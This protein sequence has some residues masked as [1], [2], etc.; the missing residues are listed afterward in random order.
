[1][2]DELSIKISA[3]TQEVKAAENELVIMQKTVGRLN[4]ELQKNKSSWGGVTSAVTAASTAFMAINTAAHQ[5]VIAPLKQAMTTFMEFGD[6]LAKTSQ[7]VGIGVESLGALKFAAEQCG[8]NFDILTDG[9]KKFQ[10]Q[11]GAASMGDTSAIEKLGK[12]GI[13]AGS[14]AGLS[15]EDQLMKLADHIAAIGDKATQTRV[16]MELFGKSGFKLLPFFQEGAAGIKKLMAEGKDIG[17]VLGEEGV[18]SAVEMTDAMNRLKTSASAISNVFIANLAPSISSVLDYLTQGAKIATKFVKDYSGLVTS[19][20]ASVAA[21]ATVKVGIVAVTTAL[22]AL[23][24]GFNALKVAMLSN[25][26]LLGGAVLIGAITAAWTMWNKAIKETEQRLKAMNEEAQK[27][28][29]AVLAANEA[30]KKLFDRLQELADMEDPL[31]NEEIREAQALIDELEGK[32]GKLGITIDENKKKIHG[33]VEAQAILNKEMAH[34]EIDALDERK[35][36]IQAQKKALED[37]EKKD[38]EK[39]FQAIRAYNNKGTA[40]LSYAVEQEALGVFGRSQKRKAQLAELDKEAAG[41]TQR[42]QSLRRITTAQPAKPQ[43]QPKTLSQLKQE[44][45]AARSAQNAA[46]AEL[47]GMKED[48]DLDF[49]DE[50]TKAYAALDAKYKEKIAALEKKI[51]LTEKAGG[52]TSGL[53]EGYNA[54]ETWR[55]QELAKI[56]EGIAQEQ[57]KAADQEYAAWKERNPE[58]DALEKKDPRVAAAEAKVQAARDAQAQAI[59][60]GVGLPEADAQ[61]KQ[62]QEGLAKSIAEAS[63][64]AR[65]KAKDD[66]DKATDKLEKAEAEGADNKTLNELTQAVREAQAAYDKENEAYFS[67]VGSLR[68][69]TEEQT[70]E[71]VQTTL[72]SAGT[73]SAYG[74]DAAVISDIPQQQLDV[75]RKLLDNTDQI[76]EEQKNEGAYTK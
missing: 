72:S 64:E 61:L 25:P 9:I 36:A 29:Q 48:A 55:Q 74:M 15:E 16:A 54:I 19:I 10:N 50:T 71:A 21:F 70:A 53:Y 69:E 31:N 68:K 41:L 63:G 45:T 17:A 13:D 11:L 62:A 66:L 51:E 30:D 58:R 65:K 67:A 32:Y 27:H 49:R 24:A 38:R 52:D 5:Y 43:E 33:M 39:H 46:K 7:R 73:F 34:K 2:A 3:N 12:A 35:K 8:A 20:G 40:K 76:K 56:G 42:Q 28:E 1:M 26:Y 4:G 22:P 37:E 60:S 57:Q 23:I 6:A 18:A 59:I 47:A 14:F 44:S 75:L